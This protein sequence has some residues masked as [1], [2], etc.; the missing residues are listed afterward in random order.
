MTITVTS[1]IDEHVGEILF[2]APPYNFASPELLRHI[3]DA[4]DAF[5][6]DPAVRCSVLTSVGKTFC[7]G[8]NLAGDDDLA[9]EAGMDSVAQLY[10]QAMRLFRRKKPMVA[11]IQGAAVGAGLGLALSADFRVAGPGA[12]FA[13]NFSR[14]G[15]HP[16][17]ALT[18]TIPHVV[19]QQRASWMMLS[20][21]RIKPE[22]A[23]D[24][25]LCDR[26]AAEGETLAEAHRMAA[27][28]AENAPLAVIAIRAT[29]VGKLVD[30]LETTLAHEHKEQT[31]LKATA[32]YEEGVA[33]VFER[34]AANFTGA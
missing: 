2:S 26:L 8:A 11:A 17:F 20:S 7:G 22:T 16:G 21:E 13:A 29:L 28:I 31:T 5:D 12:R 30:D 33:S 9:G 14:L 4:L 19:G 34:R 6:A 23:L 1:R 27:E 3:A 15:F 18:R 25:G 24:W 10:V 32:D